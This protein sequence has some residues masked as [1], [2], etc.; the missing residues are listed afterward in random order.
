MVRR[1]TT[2]FG[3]LAIGFPVL[4]FGGIPF[5]LLVL[6]FLMAAGWEYVEIFRQAG[7]RPARWLIMAGLLAVYLSHYFQIQDNSLLVTISLLALMTWHTVDY[8]LGAD[9]AAVDFGISL[10][11]WVYLGLLGGYIFDLRSL[12]NGGW[13]ILLVLPVVW[14]A[15]TGAYLVGSRIGRHKMSPRLSP[16]KSWEGFAGGVIFAVLTGALLAYVYSTLGPLHLPIW[17]GMLYGLLAG[18]VSPLGDLGESMIKRYAGL[19][20]SGNLFPG[21]GGALDRI[22]SWLW[23][24]VLGYYFILW[25]I[26]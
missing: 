17:M 7:W 25:F 15:D 3:L 21:H 24:A 2:G 8:E 23:G 1:F 16:K 5:L 12:P 11:G 20:D 26:H 18:L 13:W 10:G 22:D 9:Q 19:K 6:F 14:M 4:F